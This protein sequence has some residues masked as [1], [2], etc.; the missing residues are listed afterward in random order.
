MKNA[1]GIDLGGTNIKGGLVNEEGRILA[2]MEVPTMAHEGPDAVCSRIA[3]MVPDLRAKAQGGAMLGV[4]IGAPGPLNPNKGTIY[5]MPNLPAWENYPLK[6]KIEDKVRLPVVVENDANCAALAEAWHGAG[7]GVRTAILLT[8]GTGIGGGVLI[9]GR[10][11]NGTH[12]SAGEVGH[13]VINFNG[14]KCGCGNH[15]CLEAFCGSAGIV[16]RAWE[17]LEKPGTVSILRDRIGTDKLALTPQ[18]ISEAAE[19]GD[20]VALSVLRETG[21]LLGVG[22][23]SLANIFAPEVVILGGGV[24]RAGDVLFAAAREE[25]KRHALPPA[26]EYVKIVPAALGNNAGVIGA[27]ALLLSH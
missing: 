22:L 5:M 6:D 27:A 7:Q 1:I 12:M 21:R 24:A 10:L 23:V 15:G 17:Q 3:R 19:K 25:V 2:Q 4:G 18:L 8:L 26:N 16:N 11:V 13:I 20:G 14:P 9:D